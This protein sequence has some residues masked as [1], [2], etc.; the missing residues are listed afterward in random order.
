[1]SGSRPP[2][3]VDATALAVRTTRLTKRFGQRLVVDAVD[4]EVPASAVYGFL[5]PNGSGKTTTI[6]MLLGL[7][8][9]TA[10]A[11]WLLGTPVPAS[12]DRVLPRIGALVEAPAF[13]P[14]LSGRRNLARL[15]AADAHS[16]PRTAV[17][18]IDTALDRVGMLAAATKTFR[19]YSL[20]MRQRLAIAAALLRPRE[21]LILDEPTNALD[22]QGTR[23]IRKLM[24]DLATEGATVVVSSHLLSEIEQICS[25][26]GVIHAGRLLT[27]GT[28][29]ELRTSAHS[30]VRLRTD[31]P[32]TA[33]RVLA[34]CGM[35]DPSTAPGN[36]SGH[37]CVSGR[38]GS[39]DPGA[40]VPR[41]VAAGV[42][43]YGFAVDSPSLEE[44]FIELTGEGC[45]VNG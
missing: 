27:Q 25:H 3:S 36:S 20:G 7:I 41:L 26:V 44:I 32:G 10:G 11:G 8:H 31:D 29:A 22:P 15:D 19:A 13:H 1:M 4:L 39:V 16:D 33:M 37:T 23:E 24:T 14:Y 38:L 30:V 42:S 5:G 35:R 28:V 40:I 6:K 17:S 34:A 9:P 12:S 18:R 43:V 45:D 21:L 2:A